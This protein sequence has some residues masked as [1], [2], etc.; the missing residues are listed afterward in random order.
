MT[1]SKCLKMFVKFKL[2]LNWTII[3]N[4]F[5]FVVDERVKIWLNC[6]IKL[7]Q[8]QRQSKSYKYL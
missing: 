5:A 4:G 6:E 2:L 1:I 8:G 3:I 7:N